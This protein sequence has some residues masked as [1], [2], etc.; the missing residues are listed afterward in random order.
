MAKVEFVPSVTSERLRWA[1]SW[2]CLCMIG[3]TSIQNKRM[4][5]Q[6]SVTN[7]ALLT[8]NSH[9]NSWQRIGIW[10]PA[11]PFNQPKEAPCCWYQMNR[12]CYRTDWN[13]S[14]ISRIQLSKGKNCFSFWNDSNIAPFRLRRKKWSQPWVL[15]SFR[16]T[17]RGWSAPDSKG[18]FS[19]TSP[20]CHL[21]STVILLKPRNLLKESH[22]AG[23]G[24]CKRRRLLAWVLELQSR[25]IKTKTVVVRK[26]RTV[27]PSQ[28][29]HLWICLR[30]AFSFRK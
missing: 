14:D 22:F 28:L 1:I 13:W 23:R 12:F 24:A 27:Y 7:M 19:N 10:R 3:H 26:R 2:T 8:V 4:M 6:N 29:T 16:S 18:I 5:W 17:Y 20:A 25:V 21:P 9:P 15:R 30:T 11:M